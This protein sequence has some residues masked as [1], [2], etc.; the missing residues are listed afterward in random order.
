MSIQPE[1]SLTNIGLAAPSA[2]VFGIRLNA[3]YF[4]WYTRKQK[5]RDVEK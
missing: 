5:S 2:T 3:G 1:A 4:V